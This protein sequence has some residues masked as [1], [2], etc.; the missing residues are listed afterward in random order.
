MTRSFAPLGWVGAA[1]LATACQGLGVPGLGDSEFAEPFASEPPAW[2]QPPPAPVDAPITQPGALTRFELDNG[3]RAIV[4][5]DDR[6][7]YVSVGVAV[8]RG[9]ASEPVAQAGVAAFTAELMKRGAGERDALAFARFVDGLGAS[10]SVGSGWDDMTVSLGGLSRDTDALFEALGDVVLRPR[11]EPAE[12]DKARAEKLAALE[13]AKDDP[14]TL[15]GW[16]AAR[17]VYGDHRY[18]TPAGGSA[19]T[20]A[21]LDAAAARAFHASVFVPSNAVV[22]AAGAIDAADFERRV[23]ERFGSWQGGAPPALTAAP[24]AITPAAR[25]IVVVEKP[26]LGQARIA[27][28][29]EGLARSDERRI[30]AGIAN[31]VLGGGGFSSRLMKSVRSDAGLTYGVWSGFGMRRAPGPFRVDTFT[32]VERVREALDIV[33]A[34]LERMHSDPPSAEEIAKAKSLRVGRF[35]LGL[36]TSAAVISSLVELD[37]QGLPEDSLD[38]FRA[39]VRG[40]DVETVARLSRELIHPDRAAIVLLGP[41]EKLVPLVE[42]LGPV[43]VVQP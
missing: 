19:E 37:V 10:L 3:L 20:V 27:I 1:L 15:T 12:A 42:D 23:R 29:H 8:R 36:E 17:A 40:V 11:F 31:D 7:P 35:G 21:K 30:A 16:H 9:A 4:L 43:E 2:T 34:E 18:G 28:G 38:T 24:P 41:A 5:R 26:D 33:F 6:L 25:R 13:Q 22:F 32:Q 39:R 14:A